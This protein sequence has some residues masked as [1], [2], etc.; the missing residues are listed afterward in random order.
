MLLKQSTARLLV[1]L[2]LLFAIEAGVLFLAFRSFFRPS[3]SAL[4]PVLQ[5]VIPAVVTLRVTGERRVP[6]S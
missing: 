5:E 4:A 1:G 3:S 2:H 6:K